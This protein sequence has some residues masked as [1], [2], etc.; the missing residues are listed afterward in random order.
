MKFIADFHIHSKYSRATSKYMDLD[1]IA[2]W[3]KI[4]GIDVIGTGDFTHPKWLKE[5]LRK[6]LTQD[7]NGLYEYK[8]VKFVLTAEVSNMYTKNGRGRRIHTVLIAPDLDTAERISNEFGKRGNI[9]SDGRPIFGFDV[10]DVVKIALDASAD[11]MIIPAHI[12][13]P[14][15][16]LFGSK[17]GFD[18]IQECFEEESKNIYALE[19]GLSSDPAMNW[20][21]KALDKYNLI[22]NS[23]AHSPAKLVREANVFDTEKSYKAIIDTLRTKDNKRFL[24]TIEFFPEEG[25]YHYDGHRDCGVRFTSS[26]T[27][28]HNNICPKCN[29]PLTIGVMHRVD[30]LAD[31]EE[32]IIP[33]Q[34]VPFKS[35]VPLQ[36]IISEA[37][38]KGVATKAVQTEYNEAI[39]YFGTEFEILLNVKEKDLIER[40]PEN[41]AK[42]IIKMR[43]G[44][45]VINPGFDGE[46]G[47]VKIFKDDE[48][49]AAQ[50]KKTELF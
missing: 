21:L 9:L 31:R 3:A 13:T 17:S 40:L 46:F 41:T 49:V 26:Q 33:D 28:E 29:K 35:L 12:W 7:S 5:Q 47:K 23:D 6:K 27:K 2:E 44:D 42:A 24:S 30:D 45:L 4:K 20:R 43:K 37:K 18:S 48:L 1:H 19:T 38:G 34:A 39:G 50:T 32:G 25:K 22:S 8:G 11:C 15:F 36:E 14:W 10:K 16:S